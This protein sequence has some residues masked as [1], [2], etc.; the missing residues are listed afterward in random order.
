[1]TVYW[2][3]FNILNKLKLQLSLVSTYLCPAAEPSI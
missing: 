3:T 1:M 2:I